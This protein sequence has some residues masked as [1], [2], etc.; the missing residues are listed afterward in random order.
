MKIYIVDFEEILKNSKFYHESIQKIQKEKEKFSNE[1][2]S[3]KKDM[4]SIVNTSRSLLLDEK[5]QMVNA[6]RF[7]DLQTKGM[8][9]ESDFRNDISQF[10]NIEMEKNF[11]HLTDIV[12]DW[13]I[14]KNIDLVIN[15][16][17]T[18]FV[19]DKYDATNEIIQVLKDKDIFQ[20]FK[21]EELKT[22]NLLQ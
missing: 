8:K 11:Q 16:T 10:Q 12:K 19:L 20:E 7:K 1:M 18:V 14:S 2:E 9:I 21:E 4:E 5:S 15:K 6:N 22:E 3:I 17:Q 13:S